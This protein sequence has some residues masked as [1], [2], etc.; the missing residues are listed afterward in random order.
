[1][2]SF[3]RIFKYVQIPRD[4]L[5][6]YLFY[7]LMG[8]LFSLLSINLISPFM[9]LIFKSDVKT[10]QINSK[11]IGPLKT[12]FQTVIN[13]HGKLFALAAVCAVIIM[14]TILKNV[15]M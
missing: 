6:L 9:D 8:T 13:D 3:F 5:F 7:T 11:A 12:Y 1:M 14:T 4:K 15:F 10:P 2:K